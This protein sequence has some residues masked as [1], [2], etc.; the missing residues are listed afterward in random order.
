MNLWNKIFLALFVMLTTGAS[1]QE[2]LAPLTANPVLQEYALKNKGLAARRASVSDTLDLP[3]YDDFSDPVI[4]PRQDRWIDVHTYVNLDMSI[5]PPSFG[6]VTFDGLNGKGLAYN[7]ANQNSY[8]VADYLTSQPIDLSYLPSDSV[9]LSFYY[10]MTGLGNAPEEE[11]SLVL[12]FNSPADTLDWIH[13]WSTPGDLPDTV[14]RSVYIPITDTT[15]LQ[16][17]FQFRFKNYATLSGNVDHWH[18]DYIILDEGRSRNDTAI[19]DICISQRPPS[20]LEEYYTVPWTHFSSLNNPY[21]SNNIVKFWNRANGIRNVN[22]GYRLYQDD[23]NVFNSA[24]LFK[25]SDPFAYDSVNYLYLTNLEDNIVTNNNDSSEVTVKYFIQSVPDV[26]PENDTLT[27]KQKFYNYYAYD[28]GSAERGYALNDLSAKMA[29]YLDPLVN[30]TLRG[31]LLYF[32]PTLIDATDNR[33]KIGIWTVDNTTGGPSTLL[34]KSD[35]LYTP[36]YTHVNNYARYILDIPQY[37]DQP[38]FIGIEQELNNEMYVGFDRNNDNSDKLYYFVSGLW[39]PSELSGTLMMRPMFGGPVASDLSVEAPELEQITVYPNPGVNTLHWNGN[40]EMPYRIVD[41]QGR[42]IA[43][44][45]GTTA[46]IQNI[47]PGTYLLFLEGDKP[48]FAR[49]IKVK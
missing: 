15:W 31:L 13:I 5:A 28:D 34:Y 1:A 44:G 30:D 16:R 6:V 17:G 35:S 42:T 18:V 4:V 21:K 23:A 14:F 38:V 43:S 19:D 45:R 41:L 22:F 33:F 7:I 47:A 49:F 26:R 8:G 11:D 9:Y 12:E 48:K 25:N 29:Y 10:Q 27:F 46:P 32:P 37:I 39:L 40:A 2:L 36:R 24:V 3:F 20:I